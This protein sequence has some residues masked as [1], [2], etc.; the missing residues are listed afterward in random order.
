MTR[1]PGQFNLSISPMLEI[2]TL[3]VTERQIMIE[4]LIEAPMPIT[5]TSHCLPG[6][7]A[8]AEPRNVID[9]ICRS[10]HPA[11]IKQ[12]PCSEVSEHAL[13]PEWAMKH[14][15]DNAIT[16]NRVKR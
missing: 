5:Y 10:S 9:Y 14:A 2:L 15:N 6:V 12:N 11:D 3:T 4:I 8:Y 16:T 13:S 1:K 7:I